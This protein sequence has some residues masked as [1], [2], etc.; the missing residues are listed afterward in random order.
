MLAD[1]LALPWLSTGE[2][3]RMLIAGPRR[4]AMLKGEL[5]KD[6]EIIAL[7]RKIFAIVDSKEEFILDGFPRTESQAD[8]MLSQAKHK[9][10]DITAVIHLEASPEAVTKRLQERGRQ[11]DTNEAIAERFR[12]YEAATKPILERYK[13][14]DVEVMS[15]NAE[16]TPEAVHDE[17]LLKLSKVIDV[18][19]G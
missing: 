16:Q 12:E 15:I 4:K 14:A 18:N 13:A 8:W 19:Q 5:L 3:L 17:I 10:L 2:F 11:D 6:D 1:A 9:Q 7:V